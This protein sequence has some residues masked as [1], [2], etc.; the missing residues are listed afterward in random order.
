MVDFD[1]VRRIALSLPE[2]AEDDFH[3]GVT[4][5]NFAW[6]WRERVE[7]KKPK[8]RRLD[9]LA[10]R[11]GSPE[12]KQELLDSDPRKF[13]TEH[14]YDGYNAVLVRLK[15]LDKAE[16]RELLTDAWRVQ[17]PRKLAKQL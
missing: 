2:T 11:V 13:F 1:D 17:A 4:G 16:L 8:V 7:P 15:A 12:A 6:P 3:F 10:L 5:K 14:H 9:V